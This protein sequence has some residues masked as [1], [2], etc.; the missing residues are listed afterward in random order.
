MIGPIIP[1]MQVEGMGRIKEGP[2]ESKVA[3]LTHQ[4]QLIILNLMDVH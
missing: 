3:F 1:T 2:E 4:F